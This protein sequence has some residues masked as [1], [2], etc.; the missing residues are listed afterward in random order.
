MVEVVYLKRGEW[1]P[2]GDKSLLIECIPGQRGDE[3][4]RDT[5][6]GAILRVRASELHAHL[7]TLD[8]S[9]AA[10]VYVRLSER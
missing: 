2:E 9:R 1:R 4:T 5:S 10:K 6:G 8:E 3:A 7:A